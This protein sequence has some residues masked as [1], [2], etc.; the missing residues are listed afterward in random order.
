MKP[1]QSIEFKDGNSRLIKEFKELKS[2]NRELWK[3]V[4]DLNAYSQEMFGIIPIITMIY[5]T[6]EEQDWLYRASESYK[7]RKFKSPHQFYHAVDIR[8]RSFS[9]D[10]IIA[11]ESYLNNKYNASNYYKWSAK[12]HEVGSNGMHFHIQFCK[13]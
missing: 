8:S 5:R 4:A 12:C 9:K 11:I 3:L 7:K 10:R 1:T 13:K 2:K 6:E